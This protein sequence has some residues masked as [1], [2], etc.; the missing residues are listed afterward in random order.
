LYHSD[1]MAGE[2]LRF[3]EH[4]AFTFVDAS[5][6]ALTKNRIRHCITLEKN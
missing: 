2:E 3:P 5:E 1:M 6:N 4:Q